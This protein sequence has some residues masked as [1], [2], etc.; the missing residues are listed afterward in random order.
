[1]I[2][3]SSGA[4]DS[5]STRRQFDTVLLRPVLCPGVPKVE[6]GMLLRVDG[7]LAR[8]RP[9]RLLPRVRLNAGRPLVPEFMGELQA[10]GDGGSGCRRGEDDGE[11]F[12]VFDRL[13]ATLA[14]V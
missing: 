9:E 4:S 12:G 14:L 7:L 1:M 2:I 8:L 5:S 6:R 11:R 3:Q 13:A 10:L